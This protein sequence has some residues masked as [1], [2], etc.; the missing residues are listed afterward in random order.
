MPAADSTA[1][2][3][4]PSNRTLALGI[5]VSIGV[6]SVI[7]FAFIGYVLRKRRR[8]ILNEKMRRSRYDMVIH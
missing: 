8:T 5:G 1:A 6:S 4:G 7:A 2:S 3:T